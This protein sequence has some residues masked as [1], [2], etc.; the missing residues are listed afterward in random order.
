MTERN[1]G[2]ARP[3]LTT[4]R[5]DLGKLMLRADVATAEAAGAALGLSLPPPINCAARG[6]NVRALRL[7]PDEH[8]LVMARDV[9]PGVAERLAQALAERHRAVVDLSA[10]LFAVE[11]AG[12]AVRDVLAAG[13]P[14]DLHPSVFGPDRA[15]RTLFGKTEIILDCLADDRFRLLANRSFMPYV[16][17]LLAEAS[18]EHARASAGAPRQAGD[19]N[20]SAAGMA[21]G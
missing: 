5:P 6:D 9:L 3:L 1:L 15:S 18:R 19:E 21:P 4:D 20:H 10:R 7:G 11:I 14:L 2:G 8:L 13:C 12:P 17:L 16:R